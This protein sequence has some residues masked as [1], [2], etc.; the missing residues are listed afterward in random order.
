MAENGSNMIDLVLTLLKQPWGSVEGDR[1]KTKNP[2]VAR[3]AHTAWT[4]PSQ[5]NSIVLLGGIS[6]ETVV[7]T[8]EIVPGASKEK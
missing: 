8:T 1:V 2:S 6:G 5:P 7:N 4:P 3:G